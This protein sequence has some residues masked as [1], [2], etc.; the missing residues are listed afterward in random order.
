MNDVFITA[1]IA[2]LYQSQLN[3]STYNSANRLT[4]YAYVPPNFSDAFMVC[5]VNIHFT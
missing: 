3:H 1:D 5:S 2:N 4:A